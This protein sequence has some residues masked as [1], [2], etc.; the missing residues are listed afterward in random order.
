MLE[1]IREIEVTQGRMSFRGS[2]WIRGE[3]RVRDQRRSEGVAV[4]DAVT[5]GIGYNI[6]FLGVVLSGYARVTG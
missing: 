4:F 3:E 5:Y 2:L 1:E 6:V